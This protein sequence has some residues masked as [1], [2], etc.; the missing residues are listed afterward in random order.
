LATQQAR[1][2]FEQILEQVRAGAA[3]YVNGYVVMPE[4]VHLLLS[5]PRCSTL[6]VALQTLKQ[7]VA[8]KVAHTPDT[9]F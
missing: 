6:A 3:L 8:H 7:N 1:R 4:H 2:T 5:E 9:P